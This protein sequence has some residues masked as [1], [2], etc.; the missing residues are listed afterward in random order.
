MHLLRMRCVT[1]HRFYV[2]AEP[3]QLTIVLV[4]ELPYGDVGYG[5][6]PRPEAW[7]HDLVGRG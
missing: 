3:P 5:A 7:T 2:A 1:E 4:F 6:V